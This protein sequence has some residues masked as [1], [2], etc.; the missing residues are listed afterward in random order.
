MTAFPTY[1][2]CLAK[3][4][5]FTP[6]MS[7]PNIPEFSPFMILHAEQRIEVLKPLRS[8]V[9]Y[10]NTGYIS[11]V[12]DKGK[13]ALVTFKTESYTNNGGKKEL[14][15][16]SQSSLAIKGLGGFGY[17]GNNSTAKIPDRPTRNPD[18][19]INEESYPGQAFLYR[20]SGDPNPL[21]IKPEIA[22]MQA[23]P[24]PIIHGKEFLTQDWPL[25]VLLPAESWRNSS[26][27]TPAS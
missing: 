25:T 22:A 7:S 15:A 16:A 8:G 24:Q 14:V 19:I 5:L 10:H 17:K 6:L 26:R 13:I 27:T 23:F 4:D 12:A 2:T 18:I 21:H 9:E 3:L 20:L 11:D 1:I